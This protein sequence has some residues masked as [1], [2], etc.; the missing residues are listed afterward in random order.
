[1]LA[2]KGVCCVDEI[3]KMDKK[4]QSSMHEAMEQQT[5]SIAKAGIQAELQSRCSILG[6]A[7]PKFGRFDSNVPIAEQITMAPALMSRF[8]VIFTLTDNPEAEFDGELAQ[9]IMGVHRAG[10]INAYRD[11]H[12]EGMFTE[13]DQEEASLVMDPPVNKEFFRKYVAYA[14]RTCFPVLTNEARDHLRDYYVRIRKESN[15]EEGGA[16][17]LTARQLEAL[18]RLSEASAKIRLSNTVEVADAKRAI[19]VVEY[20]LRRI[21]GA[22]GIMDIDLVASGVGHSQ[23]ERARIIREIIED[24]SG[25]SAAGAPKDEI[26]AQAAQKGITEADVESTLAMLKRSGTIYSPQGGGNYKLA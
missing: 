12:E 26:M 6:A 17:P 7:N 14:K 23:R 18:V 3:D 10:A 24:L 13:E 1:V 21:S 5:I 16:V 4:D 2:D 22:S 19:D 8:D 20:W 9:H 11:H 25:M 15:A